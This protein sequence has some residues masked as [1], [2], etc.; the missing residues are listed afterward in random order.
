MTL[1]LLSGVFLNEIRDSHGSGHKRAGLIGCKGVYFSKYINI[2]EE[3]AASTSEE[4]S[5]P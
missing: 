5:E 2:S 3:S 1:S 4:K